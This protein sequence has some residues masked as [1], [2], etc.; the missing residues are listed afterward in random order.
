VLRGSLTLI[1]A[2]IAI[3]LP[4]TLAA[5][6]LLESQLYGMSPYDPAVLLKSILTLGLAVLVASLVPALRASSISPLNALRSE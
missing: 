3:G 5:T 1:L 6:R 4:L 2:G